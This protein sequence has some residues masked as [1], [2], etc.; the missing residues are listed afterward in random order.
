MMMNTKEYNARIL[1]VA[2]PEA[3]V[4]AAKSTMHTAEVE[5]MSGGKDVATTLSEQYYDLVIMDSENKN[6]FIKNQSGKKGI[7]VPVLNAK[8]LSDDRFVSEIEKTIVSGLLPDW[9]FFEATF[10]DD[11]KMLPLLKLE[12]KKEFL[13]FEDSILIAFKT[14]DSRMMHKAIHRVETVCEQLRLYA[15]LR[16]FYF[17]RQT[18]NFDEVISLE[19][20]T[21]QLVKVIMSDL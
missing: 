11:P 5:Y 8:E 13:Y 14:K 9:S 21:R 16:L 19:A 6:I 2:I 17:L 15:F 12:M 10:P 1:C 4:L 7:P 20:R 3:L 18:N